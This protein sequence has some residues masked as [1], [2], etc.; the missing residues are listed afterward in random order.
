M[1]IFIQQNANQRNESA[2]ISCTL[3]QLSSIPA[4]TATEIL[5]EDALDYTENRIEALQNII[6]K[7]RYGGRLILTGIDVQ[8]LSR[9]LLNKNVSIDEMSQ[10]LYSGRQSATSVSKMTEVLSALSLI[11]VNSRIKNMHYYIL[12]KRNA[13]TTTA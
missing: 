9:E 10:L 1:R 8:E 5:C 2:D 7:L 13:S 12:A 4:A 6:S 3:E 11:V